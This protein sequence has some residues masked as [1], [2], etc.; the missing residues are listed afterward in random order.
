MDR[1][2][3]LRLLA[4]GTA[5]QLA[6][7]SLL[8]LLREARVLLVSQT[9]PRTFN[10]HQDATVKA[11]AELIL[12]HTESPGATDVGASEFVDL[13]LTEWYDAPDRTHFLSGLASI[14]SR[15]QDLFGKAFVDCSV[16]QQSDILTALGDQMLEKADRVRYQPRTNGGSLSKSDQDFYPMLR[17]LI[18][19]GYYTSEAGATA[20]LDLQIIPD[21]HAGCAEVPNNLRG[22]PRSDRGGI[23]N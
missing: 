6:P 14:D 10:V 2:E 5:L 9:A 21:R 3:A 15:T 7:G 23:Q 4:T 1:R 18:L 8:R 13:M 20:E 17:R 12:P 16:L 19:T 22:D 11:M